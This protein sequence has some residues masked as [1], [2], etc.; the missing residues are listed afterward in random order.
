MKMIVLT[1]KKITNKGKPPKCSSDVSMS[2]VKSEKTKMLTMINSDPYY[3]T[4]HEF[5]LFY[6]EN[7]I[8]ISRRWA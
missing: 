5:L 6:L 1:N 8:M 4:K 7:L 3:I 2:S